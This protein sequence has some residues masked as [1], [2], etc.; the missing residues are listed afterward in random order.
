MSDPAFV[1][2][3]GETKEGRIFR[4]CMDGA[5]ATCR[6]LSFRAGVSVYSGKWTALMPCDPAWKLNVKGILPSASDPQC[7]ALWE[8]LV[9]GNRCVCHL[10]EK[11]VHH[12]VTPPVLLTAIALVK[13]LL[14][15]KIA[16]VHFTAPFAA[17]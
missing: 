11:L 15:M 13:D 14:R 16:E 10:E 9:A 4:G 7:E 6:A 8:V 17:F 3:T 12:N 1:S 2:S 5:I